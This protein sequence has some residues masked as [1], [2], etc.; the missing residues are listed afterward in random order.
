MINL[1]KTNRNNYLSMIHDNMNEYSYRN[2]RYNINY[3]VAVGL[4]DNDIALN[5]F[6]NLARET[7]KFIILEDNLCSIILDC[8]PVH[9]AI[10]AASNMQTAFQNQ[11]FNKSLFTSVVSSE[12]YT[13]NHKMINSLF[14][15]LEYAITEN[16]DNMVVDAHHL[17]R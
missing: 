8:T 4:C 13:C 14:D 12:D 2:K 10:K 11:Y 3:A 6:G 17:M 7:D 9:H 16:M 15:T 5:N 1:I